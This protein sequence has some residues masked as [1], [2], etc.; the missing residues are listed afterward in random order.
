MSVLFLVF[1][2]GIFEGARRLFC[3]CSIF[4]VVSM[5]NNLEVVQHLSQDFVKICLGSH[6]AIADLRVKF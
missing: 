4:I 3:L 6:S 5:V 1:S 2:L